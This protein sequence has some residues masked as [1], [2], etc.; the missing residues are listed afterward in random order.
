[1]DIPFGS[2]FEPLISN[3]KSFLSPD[4]FPSFI[5]LANV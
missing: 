3:S 4:F 5:P 1:M 2:S